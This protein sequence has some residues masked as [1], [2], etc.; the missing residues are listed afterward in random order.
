MRVGA[1]LGLPLAGGV[2]LSAIMGAKAVGA[3]P[4]I[5]IDRVI[6]KLEL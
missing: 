3:W 4:I 6:S 2:G 1:Q 5:A